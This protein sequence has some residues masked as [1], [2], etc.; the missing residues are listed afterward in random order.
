MKNRLE[1]L[2]NG[3]FEYDIPHMQLSGRTVRIE[4]EAGGHA[5]GALLSR[6][7]VRGRS[8]AFFIQIILG[9]FW[10]ARSF[11]GMRT[12]SGLNLTQKDFCRGRR[13]RGRS[14]SAPGS[15]RMKSGSRFISRNRRYRSLTMSRNWSMPRG[16][17]SRLLPGFSLPRHTEPG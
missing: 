12:S 10:R 14:S 11:T 7:R 5:K 8:G 16:R 17:I 4:T 15:D 2:L 1:Q 6:I 13:R 3:Q 9:F